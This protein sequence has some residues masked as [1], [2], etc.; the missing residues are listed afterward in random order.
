MTQYHIPTLKLLSDAGIPDA[1]YEL[2]VRYMKEEDYTRAFECFSKAAEQGDAKAQGGL[3]ELYYKGLGVKQN[4]TEAFK[5]FSKAYKQGNAKAQTFLA[6]MYYN[7]E[8]VEQNYVEAFKRFSKAAKQGDLEA[9]H[10]LG[11]LYFKGEGIEQN[12]AEAFKWISKAAEAGHSG[13]QSNL[14]NMYYDGEGVEQN[15]AEAF[16][17]YSRAA[18]KGNGIAM[19]QL[20][21][22]YRN[23]EG[24]Y[25]DYNKALKW[26]RDLTGARTHSFSAWLEMYPVLH[27]EICNA[28]FNIG[29]MY[30]NGEGVMQSYTTALEWYNKAAKKGHE[31]SQNAIKEIE[32]QEEQIKSQEELK[33]A[34]IIIAIVVGFLGLFI[35]IWAMAA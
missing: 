24:T 32:H 25:K 1:Q 30:R 26:F 34:A 9:Q 15:Y 11:V 21:V 17:W 3:G 31:K 19:Y 14:G 2:G 27:D 29:E 4:Y 8:G 18:D 12:Y 6:Q 22:M 35:F 10:Y 16:E 23:G 5:W 13:A 7:G 33:T 28:A 20:G